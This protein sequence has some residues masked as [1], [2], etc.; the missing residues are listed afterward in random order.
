MEP[1][2]KCFNIFSK[3]FHHN[4]QIMSRHHAEYK[5]ILETHPMLDLHSCSKIEQRERRWKKLD[6]NTHIGP[7]GGSFL[8]S[9][10]CN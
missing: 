4:M 1:E 3:V 6:I 7:S 10:K 5:C 9:H 2:K 8:A